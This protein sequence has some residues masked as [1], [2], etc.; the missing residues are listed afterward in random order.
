M[1]FDSLTMNFDEGYII[2][3]EER[4]NAF[5]KKNTIT[6]LQKQ[7]CVLTS[8]EKDQ[9]WKKIILFIYSALSLFLSGFSY[10]LSI[11]LFFIILDVWTS[12]WLFVL[13]FLIGCFLASVFISAFLLY[14]LPV[15]HLFSKVVGLFSV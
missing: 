10:V 7:Q 9:D 4:W 11:F 5:R 15:V 2:K 1:N 8:W 14:Y 3:I 13:C 6:L 12:G